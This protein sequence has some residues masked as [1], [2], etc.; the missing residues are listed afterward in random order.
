MICLLCVAF[1]FVLAS[2]N[3]CVLR[4][5]FVCYLLLLWIDLLT[6]SWFSDC[7]AT[8]LLVCYIDSVLLILLTG[9]SFVWYDLLLDYF[10][11]WL[12]FVACGGFCMRVGSLGGCVCFCLRRFV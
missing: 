11:G 3:R 12:L 1:V 4:L 9:C 8:L 7:W 2:S 6:R 5:L 10:V